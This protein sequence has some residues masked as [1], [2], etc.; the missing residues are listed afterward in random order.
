MPVREDVVLTGISECL[1]TR[2]APGGGVRTRRSRG[3]HGLQIPEGR[4]RIAVSVPVHRGN[5]TRLRIPKPEM[6]GRRGRPL[7]LRIWDETP[8]VSR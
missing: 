5:R 8:Q 7:R 4:G 1:E 3:N 2:G 6:L